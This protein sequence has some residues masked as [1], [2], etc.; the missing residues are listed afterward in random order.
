MPSA[1]QL[2]ARHPPRLQGECNIRRM[3]VVSRQEGITGSDQ[4]CHPSYDTPLP[5]HCDLRSLIS[6]S[7]VYW[8]GSVCSLVPS[9]RERREVRTSSQRACYV[10]RRIQACASRTPRP[11]E[12]SNA[13]ETARRRQSGATRRAEHCISS[14]PVAMLCLCSLSVQFKPPSWRGSCGSWQLEPLAS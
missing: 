12:S 9:V 10:S 3:T 13:R 2:G 6:K 8:P 7:L 1:L 14:R 4:G 5:F 11:G